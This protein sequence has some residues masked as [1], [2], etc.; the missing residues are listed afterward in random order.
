MKSILTLGLA[1]VLAGCGA[2]REGCGLLGCVSSPYL[3]ARGTNAIGQSVQSAVAQMGGA[4]DSA[5]QINASTSVMTWRRQ[6]YDASLGQL[7]CTET[8]TAVNGMVLQ[9][10][11]RGNCGI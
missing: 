9:Y 2:P 10:S 7:A 4:P 11:H 8:L 6:Q 5:I 1:L 3:Q